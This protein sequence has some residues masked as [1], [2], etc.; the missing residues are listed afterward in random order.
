[1]SSDQL[2]D[3]IQQFWSLARGRAKVG[4]LDVVMGRSWGEAIAPPAWSFGASTEQADTLLDLVLTGRKTA[5]SGLYE[6]YQ[7][8]G[9]PIPLEGDLSI[10]VDGSGTPKV[11]VREA[12]VVTVPFGKITP[13]QAEAEG[14]GDLETWRE[15][16]RT[17]WQNRGY[18]VDD[19]TL[20]V[21]ER[22]TVVYQV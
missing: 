4:E 17:F 19:N 12:E 9:E 1:M 5:T 7:R 15:T 3:R 21:W 18:D 11:L 20:V 10:I 16:H 6:E 22:F 8:D 13:A 14:E 2:D